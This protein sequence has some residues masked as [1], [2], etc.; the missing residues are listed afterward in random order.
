MADFF[1]SP[2]VAPDRGQE[3]T[4]FSAAVALFLSWM[5]TFVA[6]LNAFIRGFNFA[7]FSSTSSTSLNI[8]PGMKYLEVDPDLTLLPGMRVKI[9]YTVAPNNYI[10]GEVF[11]YDV[12]TG[13]LSMMAS[14]A[15]GAGTWTDW[16]VTIDAS[17]NEAGTLGDPI[18]SAATLN[19]TTATGETVHITGT[20]QIDEVVLAAGYVRNVIFDGVLNLAYHATDN[21]INTGGKDMVTA[22]G[23]RCLYWSDG[24][25]V[26]GIFIRNN[27]LS[28]ASHVGELFDWPFA[29]DPDDGIVCTGATLTSSAYPELFAKSVIHS[30]VTLSITSPGV[31]TWN[32]HDRHAN[33]PVKFTTTNA[34]PTGLVAGTTYYVIAAGLSTN[35]LRV[36]ATVGGAAINFT[37]AQAG[38]H[39]AIHSPHGCANDLSTFNVPNIVADH[40]TVQAAANEGLTSVGAV[41][42]HQ[43]SIVLQGAAAGVGTNIP[44]S[45]GGGASA[46]STTNTGGSANLAAGLR[47]R[48]CIRYK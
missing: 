12:V 17:F 16:T 5:V 31:V 19:L 38:V 35:T 45:S 21:N 44:Q 23:D 27:G 32:N 13:D 39:T 9:A 2:P 47:V 20:T 28:N 10:S 33:D 7:A 15:R 46:A 41:I 29:Y 1:T 30:A 36:S 18:A 3:R 43:H 48:K 26:Y 8:S 4:V 40:T 22:A 24:T 34:L 14:I 6:Q 42:S 37:G 25:V 11:T